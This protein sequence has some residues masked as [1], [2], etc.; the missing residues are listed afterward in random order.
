MEGTESGRDAGRPWG[1]RD[2]N[3]SVGKA[4]FLAW[5]S[6][7]GHSTRSEAE[8]GTREDT[9]AVNR[10]REKLESNRNFPISPQRQANKSEGTVGMAATEDKRENP[11]TRAPREAGRRRSRRPRGFMVRGLGQ[12]HGETERQKEGNERRVMETDTE[13]Q[14]RNK[15]QEGRETEKMGERRASYADRNQRREK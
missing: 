8:L 3:G 11:N 10:G 6:S 7:V 5:Q 13:T 1:G 2:R 4:D 9:W 14:E 12:E 15:R